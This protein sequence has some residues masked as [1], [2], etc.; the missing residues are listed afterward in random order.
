MAPESERQLAR[1]EALDRGVN[2]AIGR[3]RWPGEEDA[4]AAF[5]CECGRPDCNRL[6]EL[7]AREYEVVRAHAR[8][9]IIVPG[10]ERREVETVVL[11]TPHLLVVEKRDEAGGVAEVTDP[12]S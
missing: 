5:R 8:R 7:T 9:F 1:G 4:R 12:R 2:E 11:A 6:I 10:H 3:G